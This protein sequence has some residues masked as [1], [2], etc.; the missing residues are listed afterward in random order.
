MPAP[1]AAIVIPA[2]YKSSRFPGKPL[3]ALRGADGVS[4]S[5]IQRAWEAGMAAQGFAEVVVATDDAR[6]AE[7][8][9]GF[10]Y[11]SAAGGA[12]LEWLE[13]RELPGVAT[14]RGA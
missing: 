6:I 7:A 3:Q 12:F 9:E 5:L 4:K 2:R 8:A 14:L 11:I 13:G 10:S 1:R